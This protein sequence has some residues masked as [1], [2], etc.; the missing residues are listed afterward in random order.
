M[1]D[2]H[3][4]QPDPS[5][6]S[7]PEG[8]LDQTDDQP[9]GEFRPENEGEQDQES[10]DTDN[11]N[12][13]SDEPMES[14]TQGKSKIQRLMD[15]FGL[16]QKMAEY[17]INRAENGGVSKQAYL[18]AYHST[19]EGAEANSC[20]LN[21]DARVQQAYSSLLAEHDEGKAVQSNPRQ[22]HQRPGIPED[23]GN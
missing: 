8:K 10:N 9:E 1:S 2:N 12:V 4:H 13:A 18:A 14:V 21:R 17:V 11:H 23:Q 7:Q 19:E 5:E 6:Q 22:S 15:D 20:R 16:N 3:N